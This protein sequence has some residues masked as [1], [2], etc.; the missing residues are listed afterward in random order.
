MKAPLAYDILLPKSEDA[1]PAPCGGRLPNGGP[2]VKTFP[3]HL[4]SLSG[5]LRAPPPFRLHRRKGGR[6]HAHPRQRSHPLGV[7][8]THVPCRLPRLF[9]RGKHRDRAHERRRRRQGDGSRPLGRCRHR[10]LRSRGS[11]LCAPRRHH[12]RPHRLRPAHPPRRLLPRLPH[13]R[14]RFLMGRPRRQRSARGQKGRRS[15]HDL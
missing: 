5:A 11:H 12:G 13:R 3:S 8:C 15:R 6:C 2:H 10:L 4:A 14:A 7:L 1:R 9:R